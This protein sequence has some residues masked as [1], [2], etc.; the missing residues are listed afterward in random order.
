MWNGYLLLQINFENILFINRLLTSIIAIVNFK[1][2]S[3]TIWLK[4][5]Y[6][7]INLHLLNH[8]RKFCTFFHNKY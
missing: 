4:T 3:L 8:I 1:D 2:F 6:F 5:V 7:E